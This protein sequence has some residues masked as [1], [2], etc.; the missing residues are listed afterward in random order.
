MR[1]LHRLPAVGHANADDATVQA[2][3][4]VLSANEALTHEPPTS[5][6]CFTTAALT[7]TRTRNLYGGLGSGL[8]FLSDEGMV[9]GWLTDVDNAIANNERRRERRPVQL[10][11]LFPDHTISPAHAA[12]GSR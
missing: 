5:F 2:A 7:G 1:R 11:L 9:V 12:V 6:R 4:L 10:Q 8:G 3:A